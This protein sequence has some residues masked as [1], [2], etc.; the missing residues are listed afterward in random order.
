[1]VVF[2]QTFQP[3]SVVVILP[4]SLLVFLLFCFYRW[5]QK[6]KLLYRKNVNKPKPHTL[7]WNFIAKSCAQQTNGIM[8]I[9]VCANRN[10]SVV[11]FLGKWKIYDCTEHVC[12]TTTQFIK[13]HIKY[14]LK[15]DFFFTHTKLFRW[16][17]AKHTVSVER[18]CIT[19]VLKEEV[20]FLLKWMK[21]D[22]VWTEIMCKLC[23]KIH[24]FIRLKEKKSQLPRQE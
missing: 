13:S 12:M 7:E 9:I 22:D 10:G 16:T 17:I 14:L 8:I 2:R 11:I 4:F 24:W 19:F 6:R 3:Q 5:R 18:T 23:K 1:M 21:C 20:F 15:I